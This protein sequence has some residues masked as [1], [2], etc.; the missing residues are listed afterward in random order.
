M[1]K[2][3][4]EHPI[5]NFLGFQLF[6]WLAILTT[7]SLLWVLIGM[8]FLHLMLHS[9]RKSEALRIVT[10]GLFGFVIDSLLTVFGVFQF[11]KLWFNV[12]PPAWLCLLWFAFATSITTIFSKQIHSAYIAALL[13]AVFGPLSYLAAAKFGVVVTPL[14]TL[15]T[16]LL[17][18]PIWA[19]LF[20]LLLHLDAYLTRKN[21]N[22][23]V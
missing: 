21:E 10:L 8:L 12:L 6:W 23:L 15:N 22:E 5:V 17:L 2:G 14:N 1:Q 16:L 20:P 11:E 9:N 4:S 19:C 3:I 7:D 18:I 13:G